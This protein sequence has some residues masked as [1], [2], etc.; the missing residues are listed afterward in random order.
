MTPFT[1]VVAGVRTLEK[2]RFTLPVDVALQFS[3]VNHTL[4]LTVRPRFTK[5]FTHKTKSVTY[6]TPAVLFTPPQRS[7]MASMSVLAAQPKPFD[8]HVHVGHKLLGVGL[9]VR[10]L[11][12]NPDYHVPFTFK[13]LT[14]QKGVVAA[15]LKVLTNPLALARKWEVRVVRSTVTP[16]DEVRF[17]LFLRYQLVHFLSPH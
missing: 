8:Y 1:K 6:T 11:T 13:S 15:F 9:Q 2:T 3:S 12:A 4:S 10:G 7:V 17:R 16:V 5:V 14:K